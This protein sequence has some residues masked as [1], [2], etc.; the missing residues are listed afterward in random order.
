MNTRVERTI[1]CA[2]AGF[3]IA[4]YSGAAQSHG[5]RHAGHVTPLDAATMII[6]YNSTDQDIGV[7]FFVDS[8]GWR[9]VEITD[10]SGREIFDAESGGRLAQQGGGTELFLESVEPA[11]A[12]LPFEKFFRRFPEGTY[13]F[14]A[15]DAAG[16]RLSGT[17]RFSHRVPAGPRIVMPAPMRGAECAD[18]VP[19]RGA[20]VAWNPVI[21]SIDGAPLDIVRYEVIVENE[22]EGLTFDVKSPAANGTML[23]L[24][25]ELL[26]PG[27][28]YTG[29]VL[30]V[31]TGGNQ[32]IS[33]F[34]FTTA[35]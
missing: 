33:G 34:C 19:A 16:N 32:T 15:R 27:T 28:S 12:D 31:E 2:V 29:E 24:P 7:Q 8:E 6:E 35:D 26:Q 17:A 20:V 21:E 14:H 1:V 10:P 11:V 13:Q 25:T 22:D 9:E 3:A 4:A 18:N 5:H 23:S 30:A